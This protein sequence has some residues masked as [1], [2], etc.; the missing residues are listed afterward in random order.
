MSHQETNMQDVLEAVQSLS[1][2][3]DAQFTR[4]DGQFA[5]VRSEF[6]DVR[7]EMK[8]GF[9]DIRSEMVTKTG[10]KEELTQMKSD[11]MTEIDRFVVLHQTLS[12]ELVALRSRCERMENFMARVAKQLNLDFQVT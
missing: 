11:L 1:T 2:H 3:M 10:L 4:I 8:C 12:I 6:A 5:D 7:S 9:A